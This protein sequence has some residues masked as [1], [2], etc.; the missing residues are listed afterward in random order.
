MKGFNKIDFHK[1]FYEEGHVPRFYSKINL[2]L[3]E[4]K[5]QIPCN[6]I[7]KGENVKKAI[8]E[9]FPD[10]F[11]PEVNENYM[12]TSIF[13]KKG[14]AV[15][16]TYYS[17]FEEYYVKHIKKHRR[18]VISRAIKRLESCFD[19]SYRMYYGHIDKGHYDLLIDVLFH[20]LSE[21]FKEK[22]ARNKD[23][24]R[25]NYF[26]QIFYPLILKKQASLFVI[27]DKDKP[28]EICLNYNLEGITYSAISSFDLDYSKFSLGN[29]E[30]YYQI[31]WCVENNHFLFDLGYG[32]FN[33]K[34][35]WANL[36]YNFVSHVCSENSSSTLIVHLLKLKY[37]V[38]NFIIKNNINAG[39]YK[40]KKDLTH[41]FTKG[42]T[43]EEYV[44]SQNETDLPLEDS[45]W[46][47]VTDL[48]SKKY[49]PI[50]RHVY[51]IAYSH[52]ARIDLVKVF[53]SQLNTYLIKYQDFTYWLKTK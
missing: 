2:N 4:E 37:R 10:Y 13:Q 48:N 50:R 15:N 35:I 53:H 45:A 52:S 28:I 29:V 26:R 18:K 49:D 30:I 9:Y 40:L 47:E 38:F 16:L 41:L 17:S 12:V 8:V 11:K 5:I 42:V 7:Q 51:D 32:D 21:R 23:L 14:H 43:K 24:E 33:Y 19:I 25:Q 39:V 46:H 34:L 27:Y 31:K 22:H 1:V 6:H 36:T 20:M 44:L 3:G